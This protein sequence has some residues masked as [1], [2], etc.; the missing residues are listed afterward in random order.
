MTVAF[1]WGGKQPRKWVCVQAPMLA[2]SVTLRELLNSQASIFSS[3]KW[4]DGSSSLAGGEEPWAKAHGT[5]CTWGGQYWASSKEPCGILQSRHI[6]PRHRNRTAA[7]LNLAV[8]LFLLTEDSDGWP[9]A[10]P[11][12]DRSRLLIS[13]TQEAPEIGPWIS[14]WFSSFHQLVECSPP[15]EFERCPSTIIH[16]YPCGKGHSKFEP[17]IPASQI[18]QLQSGIS[19]ENYS[20]LYFLTCLEMLERTSQAEN[21]WLLPPRI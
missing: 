18:L 15:F 14:L 10:S 3:V 12:G 19:W 20:S 16:L 6:L 1:L 5:L 13:T 4:G 11:A 17:W 21:W 8:T 2:G 9:G 7:V